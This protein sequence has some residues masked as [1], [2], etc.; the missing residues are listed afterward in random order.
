VR[1]LLTEI[2]LRGAKPGAAAILGVIVYLVLTGP[3]GQGGSVELAI[4]C[5]L[6]AA[7]FVLLVETSPF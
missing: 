1:I 5:W 4:L 2:G 3:F 7:A 6:A